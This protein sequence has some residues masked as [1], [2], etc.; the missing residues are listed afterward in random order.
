MENRRIFLKNSGLILGLSTLSFKSFL[1]EDPQFEQFKFSPITLDERKVRIQKA[2]QIMQKEFVQAVVLDAGTS[3]EYF[4]GLRWYPSE[5]SLLA[6]IPSK[7]DIFYVCPAFEE[8]R[9]V[10]LNK[11]A[12]D[13]FTWE[14]HE[15][16]FE[17][18]LKKLKEKGF[19][20]GKIAIED[21][22]RFFISEGLK[23]IG[24]EYNFVLGDEIIVP[25]RSI[26]SAHEIELMKI[27]SNITLK[28]IDY[29][30]TFLKEGVT[31][32][33]ISEK[34]A[35]A[36]QKMGAQHDFAD[37]NFGIASSFP[38]GSS[39]RAPLKI[40]DTVM[41]DVGC[42]VGG[43]CSDITRTFVFGKASDEQKH[44]W[45]LEKKA[46]E[47]GFAAAKLGSPCENVDFAAR[48][49]V[50][51][52]G[53]GPDYKLPGVPHRT[54]HGIGMNGHEWPY[55]VKNNKTLLEPGM[56]FSI[57]PTIAL[58]GK[59]GVRLEDC[60]YMTE[61]GPQWFSKPAEQLIEI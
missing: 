10:E 48:K 60:V 58:P 6:I 61:N 35:F 41:V 24:K 9:L 29:A 12:G 23:K 42:R 51:D 28:A 31:S 11:V 57:E 32:A 2:Q 5:R 14:E 22:A 59:F 26:K 19:K 15:N 53:L 8:D 55:M 46:Q 36:H 21:K 13:I 16:P 40:G 43:Y 1:K 27:A 52:A 49:V 38:H 4:T 17:L 54:G 18:T 25:C 45:N 37:V 30:I 3:M 56:C 39:K 7:G 44:I 50:T 20:K 47:A 34:I 33:Q